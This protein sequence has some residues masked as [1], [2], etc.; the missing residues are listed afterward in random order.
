MIRLLTFFRLL[1][2]LVLA[3]FYLDT[4][5]AETFC[6][7]S[8]MELQSA[9]W[10]AQSNGEHDEIRIKSGH[11]PTQD[12]GSL[13]LG[14]H[15]AA[16]EARHLTISGG[17]NNM[18]TG[19][20]V[21]SNAF[22]TVLDGG[23]VNQVLLIA[24]GDANVI[25]DIANLTIQSGYQPSDNLPTGGLYIKGFDQDSHAALV[26]IDRVAFIGNE[27]IVGSA[28]FVASKGRVEIANSLFHDNTTN[29]VFTAYISRDAS[30]SGTS[31]FI[32]NTV[33]NNV[34]LGADSFAGIA[35]ENDSGSGNVAA[36]NVFW[37]NSN[38][39]LVMAGPSGSISNN[40]LLHNI[41]QNVF[42]LDGTN[43][44]NSTGDPRLDTDF[45]LLLDSPGLDAGFTP[46][47][48]PVNPIRGTGL[49]AA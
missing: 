20:R 25:V 5:R 15:Y 2:L 13:G 45:T 42:G 21:T 14:F 49:G 37:N 6:A 41:V 26:V 10:Q 11:Y 27:A 12:N 39:D 19:T 33:V 8:A 43:I 38:A 9:L 48:N 30:G 22:G 1:T 24:A 4:A 28:L 34:A 16:T 36:N 3:A 35:M 23:G 47:L 17:W 46:P 32:N 29:S 31:Y 18:C 44:G 7:G 40:H